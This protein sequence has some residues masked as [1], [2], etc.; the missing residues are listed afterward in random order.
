MQPL[1]FG[2]IGN[3]NPVVDPRKWPASAESGNSVGTVF[4][5]PANGQIVVRWVHAAGQLK[6]SRLRWR[7]NGCNRVWNTPLRRI[8]QAAQAIP[9][10]ATGDK[11]TDATIAF[12]YQQLVQSFLKP[13]ASL[14]FASFVATRQPG[15][16]YSPRG[17]G[18]DYPR[19]WSGQTPTLA[20]LSALALAPIN[21]E[22]A[23]GVVRNYLAVQR[24][25]GWIDWK[26]GLAGQQQG[27]LCLPMLARLT[28]GI[29]Q[30]SQDDDLSE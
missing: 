14:P 26:P 27:V 18:T 1:A 4:K 30:Y 9:Q 29:W 11:D 28:W 16:G 7:R 15:R 13:T 22:M 20:Y 17:D 25:D 24:G 10:I 8:T 19:G 23:Q 3:L 5:I 2:K 12:A 6:P 21:S